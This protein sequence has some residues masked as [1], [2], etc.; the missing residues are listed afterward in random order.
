MRSPVSGLLQNGVEDGHQGFGSIAPQTNDLAALKNGLLA[1]INA[2]Q[3]SGATLGHV[4]AILSD[5][6]TAMASANAAGA[7]A[8]CPA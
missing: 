5:L 1:E 7:A 6:T 2:G 3:Y 4:Q 8:A